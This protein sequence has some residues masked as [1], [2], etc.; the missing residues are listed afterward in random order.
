MVNSIN[1]EK[2]YNFDEELHNKF[3]KRSRKT[4]LKTD[5]TVETTSKLIGMVRKKREEASIGSFFTHN[6]EEIDPN[7]SVKYAEI[8]SLIP[9][10]KLL[11]KDRHFSITDIPCN[12]TMVYEVCRYVDSSTDEE[13]YSLKLLES[14]DDLKEDGKIER[15]FYIDDLKED[16]N[17]VV[18]L[19]MCG[20]DAV[21]INNGI[22]SEYEL[23]I[24]KKPVYNPFCTLVRR[25]PSFHVNDSYYD[26]SGLSDAELLSIEAEDVTH[27]YE[28]RIDSNIL[29]I[30]IVTQ[31]P[32]RR[33]PYYD[34]DA[35]K[36]RAKIAINPF[37]T[38]FACR[39]EYE[40]GEVR[41][42]LSG[43]SIG[44]YLVNGNMGYP[45]DIERAIEYL[46]KDGSPEALFVISQVFFDEETICDKT[47]AM[48]FLC[49]A[50][51]QGCLDAITE[52]IAIMIQ[53][54][55]NFQE[56]QRWLLEAI[57]DKE[58]AE[59]LFMKA[60]INELSQKNTDETIQLYY[61]SAQQGYKPAQCRL[62]NCITY[63]G[64]E[65]KNRISFLQ[66]SKIY[67]YSKSTDNG[68]FEY[69]LG[70][71]FL[72]GIGMNC[73]PRTVSAGIC[74]MK[75]AIEKGNISAIYEL[76]DFYNNCAPYLITEDS[77]HYSELFISI[78]DDPEKLNRIANMIFDSDLKNDSW[79]K[80]AMKALEK[81]IDIDG[82]NSNV[83]NDLGWAYM[84]G[85]GC[86][87][88]YHKAIELFLQAS[89]LGN[90]NSYYHLGE[91]YEN[92]FGMAFPQL[93]QA[94]IY[95]QKA[96]D[97]GHKKSAER[98]AEL[99]EKST[100]EVS[101][102]S[103]LD[104]IISNQQQIISNQQ[105]IKADLRA[106]DGRTIQIQNQLSQII[107]FAEND[108]Q[109]WLQHEKCRFENS[110]DSDDEERISQSISRSNDYINLQVKNVDGLVDEKAEELRK[111]FGTVWDKLLPMTQTSL[112][113]AGVLWESCA[114]ITKDA[115]DYSGI[116]I[117]STSA[118][119]C[120]LRRWF[121]VGYQE[122]LLNTVGNP[123]E[124]D[125][126]EVWD[127][128]PEEL[129]NTDKRKYRKIIEK[130]ESSPIIELGDAKSF[131]LGKL[132]FLFYNE[133]SRGTREH[134]QEYLDTIFKK[135]Y[136]YHKGGT[137]GA[138][139]WIDFQDHSRDPHSFI[140]E[141][142]NIRNDYRN[143]AAHSGIVCR[144]DAE[145][146]YQRIIG[147][148]DAY[149]HCSEVQGLIMKLYEYLD[150]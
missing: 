1:D 13:Y 64:K 92:G 87:C 138:V 141:C 76:Y 133:K 65:W 83:A 105:Q 93:G 121:Y 80:I 3:E 24:S 8:K 72:Y 11:N 60:A 50:A 96:S 106:I 140:S 111:L 45:K 41:K 79:D 103:S 22:M 84:N 27:E 14:I 40:T 30:D 90:S 35:M 123:N 47:M 16:G 99:K 20:N 104:Q 142:D 129:L 36:W 25:T 109:K 15:T 107:R 134:M 58:S 55:D 71:V 124:M 51:Q 122:Y 150:I 17:P 125:P 136:R 74:L 82:L 61:D 57:A 68:E 5:T 94:I 12:K 10:E 67:H 137:I 43:V 44:I 34:N 108:L 127:E 101:N 114:G 144:D 86:E 118:L 95:Y 48:S 97:L 6:G 75:K 117:S 126:S 37:R 120:E 98:L 143:P 81:A 128:W 145:V 131:T 42:H 4:S 53:Q 139:D 63:R 100:T 66:A 46:E 91:I 19:T 116:C 130:G 69:C 146:C 149:R 89:S 29:I 32:L 23:I 135:E 31:E 18:V 28:A 148:G 33:K 56:Q 77:S 113:S 88:D 70:T 62:S 39:I 110:I 132:P 147:R 49:K 85:R 26:I 38:Y 59:Y 21:L 52:Y 115:F 7:I 78:N 73:T 9:I 112:I 102:S 54:G 119:E 2:E